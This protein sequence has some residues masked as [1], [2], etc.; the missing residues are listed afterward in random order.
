MFDSGITA[1]EIIEQIKKEAD[2]AVQIPDES[3]MIWLN[4]VEQLLYTEVIKEQ[5]VVT[6]ENTGEA[7][8]L[9]DID[10]PDGENAVRFEDIHAVYANGVQL[11]RSTAASGVIF[12][13]TYYK[14]GDKLCVNA[15]EGAD[16]KIVYF[17]KPEIKT[18]DNYE[19][20]SA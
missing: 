6:K 2:I 19:E 18:V 17:V 10:V 7:I 4:A 15:S 12:P 13:N 8:I 3:Y 1:F 9:A 11:I 5:G 16:I 20:A 14:C